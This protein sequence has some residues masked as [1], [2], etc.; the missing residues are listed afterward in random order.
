MPSLAL[1]FASAAAA[2]Y[3]EARRR[4]WEGKP[5]EQVA[6]ERLA[7]AVSAASRS[8]NPSEFWLRAR[9]DHRATLAAL[10]GPAKDAVDALEGHA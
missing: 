7:A 9:E 5:H 1:S 4:M 3:R 6:L 10:T 8:D 2:V